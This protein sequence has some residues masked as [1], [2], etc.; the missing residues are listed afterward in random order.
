MERFMLS[1]FDLAI[2]VIVIAAVP[3]IIKAG[4]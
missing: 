2:L 4:R 3:F 1:S